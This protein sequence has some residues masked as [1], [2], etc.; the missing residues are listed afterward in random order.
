MGK[1]YFIRVYQFIVNPEQNSATFE[2]EYI[3]NG[4]LKLFGK[5]RGYGVTYSSPSKKP[6][7][8]YEVSDELFEKIV[9]DLLSK[10][11]VVL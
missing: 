3:Y 7:D 11:L 5:G 10:Q 8:F 4:R 2:G 6:D 1:V 9:T